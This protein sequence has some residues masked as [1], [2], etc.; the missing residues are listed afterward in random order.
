[1]S[2]PRRHH[3]IPAFYLRQWCNPAD[4]L[5]EYTLRHDRKLISKS[6]GPDG[7]G[8]QFDL[9]AFPELPPEQSQVIEQ[10]FFDYAD[11]RASKALNLHLTGNA[12]EWTQELVGAWSRFII[13]LHLRHPDMMSELRANARTT[14]ENSGNTSQKQ[15]ERIRQPDGP[16]T[17]DEYIAQ[18]DPLIPVKAEVNLIVGTFDH[19]DA[20]EHIN[21]MKW[22][23]IDVSASSHR[24]LTSDRPVG[25]FNIKE[26]DGMITLPSRRQSCSLRPT[27]PE[28]STISGA[29]RCVIS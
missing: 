22:A 9:Y 3:F 28:Y 10:K 11:H 25:L 6:V 7:T 14:W 20:R 21:K 18:R 23:I 4:K 24:L 19:P 13:A 8:Y 16:D 15:Y 26:A 1:M 12:A 2:V 5:I 17:F 27:I 29:G